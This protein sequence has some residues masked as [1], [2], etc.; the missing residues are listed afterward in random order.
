MFLK[1]FGYQFAAIS[2]VLSYVA[3]V[4]F[5]M[6]M[7]I[8]VLKKNVISSGFFVLFI[9]IVFTI[10]SIQQ[11]FLDKLLIRLLVMVVSTVLIGL[12]SLYVMKKL[13]EDK[14]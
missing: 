2:T 10:S 1:R 12:G 14:K 8:F 7:V 9:G 5:H 11:M 3:L 4:V 6:C 13:R